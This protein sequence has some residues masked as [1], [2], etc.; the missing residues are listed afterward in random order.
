MRT[1]FE[2]D[3]GGFINNASLEIMAAHGC[4]LTCRSCTHASPVLRPKDIAD[5][6]ATYRDLTRLARCYRS[7]E[8]VLLGGEPLLHPDLVALAEAVRASGITNSVGVHTNGVLLPRQGP[9]FWSAVDHVVVSVY[10]GH[11]PREADVEHWRT[12]CD[13]HGVMME[14]HHYDSFRESHSEHGTQD[15]DLVRRIFDTC[16]IVHEWRTH[17]LIDGA[18]YKCAEAY[19][20]PVL[21]GQQPRDGVP[22]TADDLAGRMLAHLNADTPMYACRFCL[23][24]VGKAFPH[25]QIRRREWRIPQQRP[26]EEL[27]D[28][29]YLAEQ[30][31]GLPDTFAWSFDVEVHRA[32]GSPRHNQN[33]VT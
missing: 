16:R 30:E 22:L 1:K 13:E 8:V 31:Q 17:A 2:L 4:N 20:L 6:D 15:M 5:P 28:Y 29:E 19:F 11:E 3:A 23:G 24:T 10:P 14:I 21:L 7:R 18:F 9:E 26:T 12:R 33:P 32:N 25:G 27:V